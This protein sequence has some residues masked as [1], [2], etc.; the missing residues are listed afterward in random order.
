MVADVVRAPAP[1]LGHT[2]PRIAPPAPA[3]HGAKAFGR[4]SADIGLTLRPWQDLVARYLT[5][6][7]PDGRWLFRE[8]AIV[9]AR[10]NGKT[11]I[12]VPLIVRRLLDGFS[13]MHT[14][15]N[16]KLPKE[17]H[18]AVANILLEQFPASLPRKRAISYAV[19]HESI[20]MTNG[21]KY[22]IVAPT[23]G[24][25]RGPSRDLVIIDELREMTD[26]DFIGAAKPTLTASKKP[27]M[28]YLS[29]AGTDA[30]E[31][32]NA[33][34]KRAGED[35][36]LAYLE[37]SADPERKADDL[38]GWAQSNPSLGHDPAVMETL[39]AEYRANRLAGTLGIFE[40]EHLCR[41]V[42]SLR[43][44]L[45]DGFTWA[46]L[47]TDALPS[48]PNRYMGVAMDPAGQRASAVLA[49]R[50]PDDSIAVRQILEATGD[51]IDTDLLGK[52]LRDM[53]RDNAVMSVGYDPLTEGQLAK[54][55]LKPEKINGARFANA[56]STFRLAVHSRKVR[57]M[58]C[59]PVSDDLTWTA[60]KPHD[61]SG[62]FQ[63]VRSDDDRPITA[64][65]AAIRAVELAAEPPRGVARVW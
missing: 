30:S 46:D 13:V 4:F 42:R 24:G 61:Q 18:E 56:S 32:L 7:G 60:V 41:W 23:R 40:T 8:V 27:Q 17:V 3:R 55:L 63:A 19:G 43:E 54:F 6:E 22:D 64:A 12:L 28:L 49:W 57:H 1:L 48:A 51:P 9:V 38:V 37:W 35:P 29:N 5:A 16:A 2:K 11:A 44:L 33:L 26:T 14:A 50:L 59:G 53:V 15:N 36:S 21:A 52:D 34:R 31:V 10:Q 45:V 62:S 25:A 20:R 65:L 39:T 58:D 47:A